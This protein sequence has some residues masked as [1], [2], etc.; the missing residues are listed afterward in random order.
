MLDKTYNRNGRC[1]VLFEVCPDSVQVS[2][3]PIAR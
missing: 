2:F 1:T 3:A